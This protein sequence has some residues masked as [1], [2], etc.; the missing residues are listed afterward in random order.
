MN[1]AGW[2]S[3]APRSAAREQLT[4]V[5]ALAQAVEEGHR[6]GK[7]FAGWTPSKI[8][9]RGEG[10]D[11]S[12]LDAAKRPAEDDAYTAPEVAETGAH[13]KRSD[14]YSAGVIFYEI[15]AGAH[16]FGGAS[17]PQQRGAPRPLSE[18]RSDLPSDL[19]DGVTACLDRD[20]EWR[21]PDL[22]YVLKVARELRAKGA[23]G[24]RQAAGPAFGAR[25]SSPSRLSLVLVGV[26]I[27]IIA[28]TAAFWE[29]RAPPPG[30]RGSDR[31]APA[32]AVAKPEPETPVSTPQ[33]TTPTP[34]AGVASPQTAATRGAPTPSPQPL[35]TPASTTLPNATPSR[36]LGPSPATAATGPPVARSTVTPAV[37]P[38][39]TPS[40]ARTLAASP[41]APTPPPA[42]ATPAPTVVP[43][44]TAESPSLA[45]PV[46]LRSLS[47]LKIR[48]GL[49][50][51]LDVRGD[52]L[53]AEDQ[54]TI[55]KQKGRGDPSDVL[56][57]RKKLVDS[58][59]LQVLVNVAPSAPTGLYSL[60]VVDAQGRSSN[61][62]TLEVTQ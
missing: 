50:G 6:A 39:V 16:P 41:S 9:I 58:T 17:V 11:L 1:L 45:E 37:T 54:V 38:A 24:A 18:L 31:S 21:S 59:L 10:I 40:P 2:L 13:S 32:P 20:P 44:G 29:L 7:Q 62:L 57:L 49:K 52:H 22:S 14:V 4:L 3:S 8:V 34:P 23:T 19:T 25:P 55:S 30:P 56:P 27:A 43:P 15:L 28:G 5:T 61:A 48:R 60:V 53:R 33:A 35:A 26:A 12:A 36:A 47:P 51:L 42:V 46:V